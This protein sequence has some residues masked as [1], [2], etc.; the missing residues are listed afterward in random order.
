MWFVLEDWHTLDAGAVVLC[1]VPCRGNAALLEHAQCVGSMDLASLGRYA[2]RLM[3]NG[4]RVFVWTCLVHHAPRSPTEQVRHFLRNDD[5]LHLKRLPIYDDDDS[6]GFD[7]ATYYACSP[8]ED[9]C[10]LE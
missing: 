6:D 2:A 8:V 1:C 9:G 4:I 5:V 7:R 3:G 10:S